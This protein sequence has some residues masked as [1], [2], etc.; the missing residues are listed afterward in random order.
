[1]RILLFFFLAIPAKVGEASE[2]LKTSP[3][4]RGTCVL[5]EKEKRKRRRGMRLISV[6]RFSLGI[7]GLYELGRVFL[8]S[9]NKQKFAD[10]NCYWLQQLKGNF[11]FPGGFRAS[12][13]ERLSVVRSFVR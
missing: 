1:M 4:K 5:W 12:R 2:G 13:L 7:T 11:R 10:S 6:I 9:L 8:S 3:S